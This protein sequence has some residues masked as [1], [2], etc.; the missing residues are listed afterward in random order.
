[1]IFN[2]EVDVE[3][4]T[5]AP[6]HFLN[7]LFP[8]FSPLFFE[9]PDDT[10]LPLR[11]EIQLTELARTLQFLKPH[12]QLKSLASSTYIQKDLSFPIFYDSSTH[13]FDS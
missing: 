6:G 10:S 4:W 13:P 11:Y 12:F 1:M 5:L 9:D 2:T 7:L 8:H 3:P